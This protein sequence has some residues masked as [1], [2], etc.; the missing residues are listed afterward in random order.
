MP[1][2]IYNEDQ[3]RVIQEAVKWAK[4]SSEQT[5]Q[6]A[7]EAGTGKSVTL[8]GIIQR[9]GLASFEYM[10]MAYT[11]QASIVMRLKGFPYAKSIHSSL[12]QFEEIIDDSIDMVT[13]FNAP[14]K[15]RI[16]RPKPKSAIPPF[17]KY[18]IIDEGYLPPKEMRSVIESYGRKVIVA[19]DD[20]QLPP[21]SGE[22]AYLISG[23]V[24]RLNKLMRQ[25]EGSP[26]IYLAHRAR[27]GLPIHC[28]MYG[29]NV[30]VIEDKDI[31]DILLSLPNVIICG[32][33]ATRDMLNN[34]IRS[35]IRG[36]YSDLPVFGDRMI[37]RN[38]NWNIERDN[39]SLA[40]GLVGTIVNSPDVSG[41][42]GKTFNIDFAPDLCTSIFDNLK[43]DYEY[44][45]AP[46]QDRQ[47]M[48]FNKYQI[49]EKFEFA[50]ALTGYLSQGAEYNTVLYIE[51][52]LR[53][54][55]QN[56]LNYTSITRAKQNLIYVKRSKQFYSMFS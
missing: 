27:R 8:N 16:F 20:G 33:N 24:H 48:K 23:K 31:N 35:K 40:N 4:D 49:G 1:D 41:Y 21:V 13:Q 34:Y 46:Y 29:Q 5:F 17:V 55:I 15:R 26:I 37:C 30:L 50:Y 45:K 19:G 47:S 18:F 56:Q 7:G 3:E 6:F 11:G 10:P 43:V 22:P 36:I 12:Y 53:S 14:K 28:G 51:E 32:T 42:N 2:I 52:F 54:N 9:L 38:N 39:I 25:A 44:Y